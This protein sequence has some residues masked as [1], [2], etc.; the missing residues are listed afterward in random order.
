MGRDMPGVVPPYLAPSLE[1]DFKLKWS[2]AEQ[3]EK[4]S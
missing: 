1:G 3:I 4:C 2:E